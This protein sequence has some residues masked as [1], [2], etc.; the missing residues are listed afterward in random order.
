[1]SIRALAWMLE[2]FGPPVYCY[3]EIVH[4]SRVKDRFAN[5]GVVFVNDINNVPYGA[6]LMLSA[7]GTSPAVKKEALNRT[8]R[9]VDS[10]CPLVTK[11]HH[12]VKNRFSDGYQVLYVGHP[13]HDEQVATTAVAPKG[14]VITV[15]EASQV[16]G[17]EVSKPVA[18]L[19][20]TTL[21]ESEY[22]P[23][24]AAV[25]ERFGDVWLPAKQDRCFATTN[26][27]NAIAAVAADCDETIVVGS[28]NSANTVAL[29]KVAREAGCSSVHRVNSA[30]EITWEPQ[31]HVAV[32]AGASAPD[33]TIEEVLQR[34]SGGDES[35]VH[36]VRIGEE[37]EHFQ[38]P[39]E[40]RRL[41]QRLKAEESSALDE[42]RDLN[43][44]ASASEILKRLR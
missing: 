2:T 43:M 21:A 44:S 34:V 37:K 36:E 6:A 39:P 29:A 22:A 27:Q 18:L 24:E 28:Q 4:N 19:T 32:T 42:G 38:M 13:G 8:S 26:R 30:S 17:I 40:L 16:E 14:V 1:M 15:S 35:L 3:H 25:R 20:Q 11:V 5:A 23:I 33:E 7:H 31:G 9:V 12:E 10:V 41:A